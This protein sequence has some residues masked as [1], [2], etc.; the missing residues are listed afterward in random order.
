MLFLIIA[1]QTL[2]FA[3]EI[4]AGAKELCQCLAELQKVDVYTHLAR[5]R[6]HDSANLCPFAEVAYHLN[7]FML[8]V[9]IQCI[10][11]LCVIERDAGFWALNIKQDRFA[12][13][14]CLQ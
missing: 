10:A 12:R 6:E 2:A 1:C 7:Q 11:N 5:S 14:F 9:H 8:Q 4:H 13:S 3:A